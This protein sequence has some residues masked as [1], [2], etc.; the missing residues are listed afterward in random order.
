MHNYVQN[1]FTAY[2]GRPPHLITRSPGRVNL[3]GDHTDYNEGW[4]LP[5]ALNL[6]TWI[7][8]GPRTDGRLH[9][10]AARM[11]QEDDVPLADLCPREGQ[12]WTR[13]VRG[14]AALLQEAGCAPPGANLFIDGD[15]P[16]TGGLS[17][18][19]SL[20]LGV[21]VALTA[22]AGCPVDRRALALLSQRAEHESVGVQCG[23]MDQLAVACGVAGHALLIDCRSYDV[24]PVPIPAGL[25]IL[26]L[27]SAVPRTLATSA[28][29]QRRAECEE[30]LGQLRKLYPEARALRDVMPEMLH[31]AEQRG[32]LAGVPLK[33][34][35]HVVGEDARVLESASFLRAGDGVAFGRLMYAS[36]ASLRDDYEVSVPEMDALVEIAHNTPGILGARLTG[37][38]FGG[39]A[40]ALAEAGRAEQALASIVERYRAQTGREGQGWVCSAED[41]VMVAG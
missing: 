3:I 16:L 35:R 25:R 7:A 12:P 19:A 26:V 4:V 5:A 18:S 15:L 38:G 22:L 23:I 37:A 11:G 28:Y 14:V 8:T 27:D 33:R 32:L 13:Y 2:F 9:T 6:G 24:E 1:G 30:A 31:E 21:A 20:E 41:G 39:S 17:S 29:N 36:H 40:M 10:V 34:A